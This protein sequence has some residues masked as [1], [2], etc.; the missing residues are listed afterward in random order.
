VHQRLRYLVTERLVGETLHAVLVR[1]TLQ[2]DETVA[3]VHEVARS[4]GAAHQLGVIHRDIKPENLFRVRRDGVRRFKILDLGIAKQID[5]SAPLVKT[6]CMG[7]PLY[8]APESLADQPI[9]DRVDAWGLAAVAYH[10]LTG[11][12]PFPAEGL[13]EI[14][15]TVCWS[16]K[17]PS[18]VK[19]LVPD[20][21][22][23]LDGWLDRAL[24]RDPE[25]RFASIEAMAA[26]FQAAAS[27][28]HPSSPPEPR[29]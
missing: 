1:R 2:L 12:P 20:A 5:P 3:M 16:N 8:M 7:T 25:R 24:A 28:Q 6:A 19:S 29:R 17:R 27:G 15:A 23:A 10:A 26:A 11:R 13:M 9:D 18:P 4:L 14:M 22:A 21:P